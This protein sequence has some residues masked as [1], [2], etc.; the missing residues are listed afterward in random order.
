VEV[1]AA[2]GAPTVAADT[3]YDLFDLTEV[4]DGAAAGATTEGGTTTLSHDHFDTEK[5][6]EAATVLCQEAVANTLPKDDGASPLTNGTLAGVKIQEVKNTYWSGLLDLDGMKR[7][8]QHS[9]FSQ[10]DAEPY[11]VK[12]FLAVT[13]NALPIV[14]NNDGMEIYDPY[15]LEEF[16]KFSTRLLQSEQI[17]DGDKRILTDFLEKNRTA[18]QMFANN[19]GEMLDKMERGKYISHD[20]KLPVARI[21][22]EFIK[23]NKQTPGGGIPKIHTPYAGPQSSDF[24]HDVNESQRR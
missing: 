5:E 22:Y 6:T 12:Y 19:A 11:L 15:I 23:N 20:I 1:G 7:L 2:A 8:K 4:E 9:K 17:S 10:K 18:L 24:L 16:Y 3:D 14:R 13:K 21:I